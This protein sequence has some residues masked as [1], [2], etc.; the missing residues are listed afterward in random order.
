[1]SVGTRGKVLYIF[2]R[3]Y[4]PDGRRVQC[5]EST[6]LVDNPRNRK[7]VEA[8]DKAIKYELRHGR[9]DYLHFFP[10]GSKAKAFR[11][12]RSD[13][14]F[15]DFW[16]RWIEAKSIRPSTYN[17]WWSSYNNH[18]GPYFGR[19]PLSQIS[20][21]EILVFRKS[22]EGK[23]KANS[24]N[25]RVIKPLCMA[26][27]KAHKEGLIS[28]YPCEDIRRLSE[29]PVDI[30]PFSFEELTAFLDFLKATKPAW[31]DLVF[32]WSRT[33]LR[34]GEFY[35]VKWRRVDRFNRKLLIRE[36][37][38]RDHDGPPKTAHSI[39]DVD[40][41]PAVLDALKRQEARTGLQDSYIFM[42]GA[43]KPFSDAFMRNKFRH[44][45]RL[46]GLKYRPPKQL[47]HTFATL[48]IA[49]GESISWVSKTLGHASVKITLEKYNRFVPNLTHE[50]GSAFEKIMDEKAGKVDTR[51]TRRFK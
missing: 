2:F 23:L 24:I 36:T 13:T 34:P 28:S 6:G 39:R 51:L 27:L 48:H 44:L 26:L 46:A 30:D 14:L 12:R 40:L 33:G 9:F 29:P 8:K 4:L 1:M 49:A 47:R 18:I 11:D 3:C 7:V 31:Y 15:K 22:L 37:R 10:N 25:D 32:I 41:R 50:D 43:G 19:F 42:T 5:A 21:H 20:E 35:A 16:E 17:G 38:Y 45:L